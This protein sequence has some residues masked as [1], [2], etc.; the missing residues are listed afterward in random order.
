MV[1]S[2]FMDGLLAPSCTRT[3]RLRLSPMRVSFSRL[4]LNVCVHWTPPFFGVSETEYPDFGISPGVY[5]LVSAQV[6]R[7]KTVSL[8]VKRWSM[9]MEYWSSLFANDSAVT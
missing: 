9:R 8:S 3:C 5:T 4:G 6:Q 2:T 7:T 1:A